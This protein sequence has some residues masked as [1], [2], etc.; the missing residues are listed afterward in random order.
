MRR[1][2]ALLL[3]ALAATSTAFAGCTADTDG[4]VDLG[5]VAF[6]N[7]VVLE[8]F[9]ESGDLAPWVS[10]DDRQTASCRPSL[11]DKGNLNARLCF[12]GETTTALDPCF[13]QAE[14]EQTKAVCLPDPSGRNAVQLDVTDQRPPEPNSADNALP[15]FVEL[16]SGARCE[17][18]G[19][20]GMTLE[21]LPMSYG[22]DDGSFVYGPPD[23]A[24]EVWLVRQQA[25]GAERTRPVPVRTAWW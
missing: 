11:F 25:K 24:D 14:G 4:D 9:T 18:V 23:S 1:K 13:V 2:V 19:D 21:G 3:V 5:P 12:T 16:E 8:P 7:T 15:W 20:V 22:C 17:V 10:V 6:T